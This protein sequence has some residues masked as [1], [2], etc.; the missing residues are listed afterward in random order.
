MTTADTPPRT[1]PSTSDNQLL[2]DAGE[3]TRVEFR[4]LVKDYGTTRVL[5]GLDL[6]IAPGEFVS[7][8]GPSGCGGDRLDRLADELLARLVQADQRSLLVV[9]PVVDVEHILQGTDKRR[10][11][12][13]GNAP[14]PL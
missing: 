4:G 3:G 1:L 7:L 6:D 14:L 8:L 5:H 11:L 9:G 10:V 12:L 2:A 13:R